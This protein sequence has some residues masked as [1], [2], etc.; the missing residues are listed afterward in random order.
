MFPDS[1]QNTFQTFAFL[2][3][4]IDTFYINFLK[5]IIALYL[6]LSHKTYIG[7]QILQI[8]WN[9]METAQP[10]VDPVVV[11]ILTNNFHIKVNREVC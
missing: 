2:L 4:E 11:H 10:R 3:K 9:L 1:I 8:L 5:K 6:R 7:N